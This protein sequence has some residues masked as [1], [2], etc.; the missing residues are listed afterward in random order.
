MKDYVIRAS[1]KNIPLRIFAA[2]TQ[3]TVEKARK[4]HHLTPLTSAALGRVLT[5][6]AMMGQMLKNVED[7]LTLQLKGEGPILNLLATGNGKGEVKGYIG[8]PN[9][10]LPLNEN[11]KLDVGKAIGE[12]TLTVIMDLGLKEPYIGRVSLVNGEIAEDLAHYFAVSEQVPS[13]VALGVLVGKDQAIQSSGGFIIQVMPNC[14]ENVIEVLEKRLSNLLPMTQLLAEGNSPED[15]LLNI[16]SDFEVEFLEKK[17]VAYVCNCSKERL[18]KAL[19]TLGKEELTDIIDQ[20]GQAELQ[21]HFCNKKYYFS[22]QELKKLLEDAK[23]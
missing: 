17:E 14:P 16:L 13:A 20:D 2:T 15:I 23:Q 22:K 5:A 6:T 10:D 8:N 19:I 7:K 1:T 3:N 12:G 18:G 9:V 4:I 11:G 21:C